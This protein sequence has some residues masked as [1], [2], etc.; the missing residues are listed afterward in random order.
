MAKELAELIR[1]VQVLQQARHYFGTVT[2]AN[3]LRVLLD[4]ATDD[5]GPLPYVRGR[6]EETDRVI[7]VN[8]V[9]GPNSYLVIGSSQSGVECGPAGSPCVNY[10]WPARVTVGNFT[11]H[12]DTP[13]HDQIVVTIPA[14]G[15]SHLFVEML[16]V[17]GA[18]PPNSVTV[19]VRLYCPHSWAGSV[20]GSPAPVYEQLN[21]FL[22]NGVPDPAG[23][24]FDAATTD[25]V[26]NWKLVITGHSVPNDVSFDVNYW[27]H[28]CCDGPSTV[29]HSQ[30]VT[31]PSGT[32]YTMAISEIGFTV[33][34]GVTSIYMDVVYDDLASLVAFNPAFPWS[35]TIAA[36]FAPGRFRGDYDGGDGGSRFIFSDAGSV[37]GPAAP[38]K[39]GGGTVPGDTFGRGADGQFAFYNWVYYSAYRSDIAPGEYVAIFGPTFWNGP[40]TNDRPP[41]DVGVTVT[42]TLNFCNAANDAGGYP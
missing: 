29:T 28:K 5:I 23:R 40:F 41:F 8:G 36:I 33:P 31:I 20:A 3:P 39:F 13:A 27:T 34:E 22:L 18:W 1:D 15:V 14:V 16:N 25:R 2:S 11:L 10:H 21:V 30:H 12:A 26:G 32:Q 17:L 24:I 4:G 37:A 38:F 35:Q 9:S 6:P 42:I 19:D 7:L